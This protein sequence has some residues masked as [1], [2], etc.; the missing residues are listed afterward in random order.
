MGEGFMILVINRHLKKLKG[1]SIT[2]VLYVYVYRYVHMH[3][4]IPT[5]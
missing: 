2:Y 1:I 5:W 4:Y 3:I